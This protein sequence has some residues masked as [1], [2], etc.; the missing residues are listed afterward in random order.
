LRA[1]L[2]SIQFALVLSSPIER[3]SLRLD[4]FSKSMFLLCTGT[5]RRSACKV[6]ESL[7]NIPLSVNLAGARSGLILEPS[8]LRLEFF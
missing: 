7:I 6:V 8:D 2:S 1:I 5:A 3:I 4:T